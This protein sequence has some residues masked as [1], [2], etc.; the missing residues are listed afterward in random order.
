M[1]ANTNSTQTKVYNYFVSYMYPL[2]MGLSYANNTVSVSYVIDSMDRVRSVERLLRE[3]HG[4]ESVVLMSY[5]P[6]AR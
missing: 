1:S 6:L 5:V 3:H 4:V 2:P